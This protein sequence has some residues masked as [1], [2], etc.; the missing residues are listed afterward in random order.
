V[1]GQ[2]EAV[3]RAQLVEAYRSLAQSGVMHGSSG[4]LSLRMDAGMLITPSGID[5]ARIDAQGLVRL[6]L[7][8]V[9]DGGGL[10]SSEWRMHA[11]IYERYPD[12]QAVVHTH[13]DACVALA[14]LR[15]GLPAFHY[16]VAGFGGD[17]VRCAPY[18]A[19]GSARLAALA[20]E[21]LEGR[22]ACLLANHGMM[23]RGAT[24]AAALSAAAR[25]ETLCRQYLM[26]LNAGTP[27][28]LDAEEMREVHARY[29]DYGR[30]SL[31]A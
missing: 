7:G 14:C 16:M 22:T 10:P 31:P 11:A 17:D 30:A 19:F 13:A 23:A 25:L 18:A 28:L 6:S 20:V 3:L 29:A 2:D 9:V 15:R 5:A 24:M 1:A 26:T 27:I 21:A 12:T 8:G 4:N